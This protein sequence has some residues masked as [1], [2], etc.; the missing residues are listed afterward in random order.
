MKKRLLLWKNEK[1]FRKLTNLER[2][3]YKIFVKLVEVKFTI[4][5]IS[6]KR[7]LKDKFID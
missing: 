3:S 7:I 4:I 5:Y 6:G 1:T 2:M